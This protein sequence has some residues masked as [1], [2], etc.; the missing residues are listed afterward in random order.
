M[1]DNPSVVIHFRDCEQ[2]DKVRDS[3]EKHSARLAQEFHEISQFEISLSP[4]GSG[5]AAHIHVTGKGTDVATQANASELGP[6][7]DL[8]FAKVERQLRKIHDKRIFSQRREAQR[9][10]G[11]RE[12]SG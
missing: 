3:I 8:V 6:A 9:D 1:S 10:R 11:R 5:F 12:S 2:S 7:A 4:N